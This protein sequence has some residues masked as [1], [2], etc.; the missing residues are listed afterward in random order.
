[1][2]TKYIFVTGGVVSGVGKGITVA[3]LGRL[4]KNRGFRV[5]IQKMDPYLNVDPGTM[6]PY[7]HG[8]VFVTDDGAETDLDLGHY[9][10]FI[11]ENLTGGN[12]ITTGRIYKTVIE[13]ERKGDYLGAT[14]QVIPHITDEIK[15]RIYAVATASGVDADVVITEV[16]GTVGDIESTPFLE[17]IRQVIADKGRDN[18][19]YIHVTLVP[20]I[21]GSHELKTKPTQHSVKTLLSLGI[22]PNLLVLRSERGVPREMKEKIALFC[23]VGKDDVINCRTASSLY[24]VPLMLEEEGLTA[25]VCRLLRLDCTKPAN[26]EVWADMVTRQTAAGSDGAKAVI[27]VVG[28]YTSLPDAYI[29]V[30]EAIRHACFEAGLSPDIRLINSENI[31][32]E[33]VA[34]QLAGCGAVVVPGGFGDRGIE[35]KIETVRYCRESKL[36]F[37]GLCLGMHMAVIEYARNALGLPLANS[38]EFIHHDLDDD[39]MPKPSPKDD[40][41]IIDFM[42][43]QQEADKGG[44]MRLG[45]FPCELAEGTVSRG[46]YGKELI[47]ERHRHRYEFNNEFRS[48]FAEKGMVFSGLFAQKNL[49][50]IVE[51]PPSVHPFFVAVQFHPEFRSRPNRPHPLFVGLIDK[52]FGDVRG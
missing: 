13:K 37:L 45:L 32:R 5:T 47:H 24:A 28:K 49:V 25:A 16:G 3:S 14:V 4:L 50:E 1:M 51:L 20:W 52:A 8:E 34:E 23:N 19:I 17:A 33:N 7:Q 40:Y 9:E 41:K 30:N 39:G 36:P 15:R 44:T 6:S 38:A 26:N 18:V 12:N 21:S 29:S 46:L 22:Q 35:G 42:A 27:G 43:G 48:R 11:D 10:R 2:N 31:T